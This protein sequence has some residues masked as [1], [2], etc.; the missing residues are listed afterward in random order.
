MKS[1]LVVGNRNLDKREKDFLKEKN[2][3]QIKMSNFIEDLNGTIESIMEFANGK[4]LY[5]SV[6]IDFVDPVFAPATGCPEE[7][8]LSSKEFLYLLERMSKMQNLKAIDLV[9]INSV[10]DE[11]FGY[12]TIKLGAKVLSKFN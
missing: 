3:R 9:E 8:G 1:I 6:D 7:G 4:A 5:V 2:I 12:M 10:K 11:K